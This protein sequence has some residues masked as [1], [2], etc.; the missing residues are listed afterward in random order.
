MQAFAL[1][2][3]NGNGFISLRSLRRVAQE[4]G[5]TIPDDELQ[6]MIDEFDTDGDGRIDVNDFK[7]IMRNGD[8]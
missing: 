1:F 8:D 3:D 7:S 5:E 2:D 4:L 6:A